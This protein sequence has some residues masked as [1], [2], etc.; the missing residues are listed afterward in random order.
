[1]LELLF[2][3]VRLVIWLLSVTLGALLW[4][5][6]LL[7]SVVIALVGILFVQMNAPRKPQ[8]SSGY[9]GGDRGGW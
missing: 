8:Q 4:L 1:M 2:F 5:F 6:A 3:P 7:L 9:R